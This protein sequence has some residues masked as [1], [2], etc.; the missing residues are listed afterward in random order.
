MRK[1]EMPNIVICC[2]KSIMTMRCMNDI[3]IMI[4]VILI[5]DNN[6]YKYRYNIIRRNNKSILIAYYDIMI[7]NNYN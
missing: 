1:S 4:I 6:K 5:I 2:L 3:I 7:V